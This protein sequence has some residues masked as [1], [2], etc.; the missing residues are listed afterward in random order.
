MNTAIRIE[1]V[2]KK[3]RL[4][5]VGT[6]TLSHDLHRLWASLRG[7][8]DPF[9]KVGEVN[10]REQGGGEYAW[11]LKDVTFD[12]SQGEILG[13][14]GRNG[15]GKSTLLKLLSRVTAP[16]TGCIKTKGRIAS[17]LEVGTG[18]HPELTGR[19][20]VYLNGA[21]MGMTRNEVMKR[22]DEIVEFSGCA[23]YI[24]TPVKRYS[25]GMTVRLGFSVAAHLDCEILIVDEV[26]AVG[27]I[28]FQQKCLGKIREISRGSGRTVIFVSHNM[29]S[30]QSLCT[31]ASLMEMGTVKATGDVSKIV[32]EYLSLEINKKIKSS[33]F[34]NGFSLQNDA[35]LF[36]QANCGDDIEIAFGVNSLEQ[37]DS[38]SVGFLILGYD[39]V[40]LGGASSKMV[41]TYAK[42][43][44]NR[45]Y[46]RLTLIKP[47]LIQGE[48]KVKIY[49]GDGQ[50]D[51][52]SFDECLRLRINEFDVYRIGRAL[53]SAWGKVF[54]NVNWDL[55]AG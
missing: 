11:A 46:V 47:N 13:I 27:D 37:I 44:A 55:E 40:V 28:S 8:P 43:T 42:K 24:D 45:W 6:G 35:G 1:N 14:I 21:I 52:V 36:F 16:T 50:V 41:L 19:E 32:E 23:K 2:S 29:A 33:I 54:F 3:Y 34:K 53:P 4:G 17:L 7:Q 20:N 31:S 49:L 9:A 25:S 22:L 26:L 15:A 39:D 48:Y 5:E 10:D 18:F 38:L 30:V 12:V 51:Q